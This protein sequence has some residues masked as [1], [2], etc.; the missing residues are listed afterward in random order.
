METLIKETQAQMEKTVHIFKQEMAK[1]R[2]GRASLSI[3]DDVKVDY[4][5]V[6]TPLNQVATLNIPEPKMITIAPWES[7]L[8]PEIEKGI[9]KASLG[10]NPSNDGKI[11]RLSIPALNEERRKELVKLIKKHAEESRIALRLI[12]R[13]ANENLKKRHDSKE[14][15]EDDF[16]KAQERVQKTTDDYVKKV[17]ELVAHKEKDILSV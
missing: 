9:L 16:K 15:S 13:D 4:Y 6:P 10:L 3:L 7:K 1:V 12:R 2:A 11:V 17:D 8:I 5:G 14:L